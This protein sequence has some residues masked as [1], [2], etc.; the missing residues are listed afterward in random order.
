[1]D[2]FITD[3]NDNLLKLLGIPKSEIVDKHMVEILGEEE[4]N[5]VWMNIE[6]GKPYDDVF[7]IETGDGKEMTFRQKYLPICDNV[8][9]ILRVL[10][11]ATLEN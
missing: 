8:G 2:G 11:I 6:D 9:K 3:I 5:K 7:T 4:Y 1:M 10:L